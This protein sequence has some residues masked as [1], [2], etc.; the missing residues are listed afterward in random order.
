MGANIK[1]I[2]LNWDFGMH[3]TNATLEEDSTGVTKES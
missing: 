2:R 1:A 3:G